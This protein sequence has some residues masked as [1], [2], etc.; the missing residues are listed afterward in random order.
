[1]IPRVKNLPGSLTRC[2][3]FVRV[4]EKMKFFGERDIDRLPQLE[5]IS[6]RERFAMKV[7]SQVLP[8]RTNNY[9]VEDL[10]DWDRVPDDPI[11]QLTFL[12]EKCLAPNI[13]GRCPRP[14]GQVKVR[15][16]SKEFPIIFDLI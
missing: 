6:A 9:V 10:I 12:Q 7:V 4:N 13:S 14:F 16:K 2:R 1:M 11:Y 15:K 8:F 5:K 3:C